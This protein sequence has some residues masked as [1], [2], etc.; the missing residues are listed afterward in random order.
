LKYFLGKTGDGEE[1]LMKVNVF[2]PRKK[3]GK[4][5]KEKELQ[6]FSEA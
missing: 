5:R 3:V 2:T 1:G 4:V 6:I